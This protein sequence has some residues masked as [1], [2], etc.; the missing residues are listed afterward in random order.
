MQ[1][2]GVLLHVFALPHEADAYSRL[3]F[4]IMNSTLIELVFVFQQKLPRI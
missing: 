3:M 1:C 2:D 4:V